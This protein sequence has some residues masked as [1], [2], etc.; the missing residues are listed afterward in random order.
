MNDLTQR[1]DRELREI[2]AAARP[3]Q[4][5]WDSITARLG[6]EAESEVVTPIALGRRRPTE[7]KRP[8]WFA[9]VAASIVV[10][11]GLVAMLAARARDND[12]GPAT[13]PDATSPS[14]LPFPELTTTFVSPRMGFSVDY[15]DRGEGTLTP[16]T[17]PWGQFVGDRSDD[18]FDLIETGFAAMFKGTSTEVPGH[19][20]SIDVRIDEWLSDNET[21]A[22]GRCG[23]PRDQQA[24]VTIDGRS[25][26]IAEC[27]NR[28]EATVVAG[29]RLYYFI[30]LHERT[31]ARR[32]FDAFAATIHLTPQTAV[33]VP[34]LTT[35]FVSPTNEFSFDYL[36][37]GDGT[38]T[39]ATRLWDPV[40]QPGDD[41]DQSGFDVVETGLGAYFKGASTAIPDGVSV[42]QWIDEHV[43]AG[44]CGIPRSKQ[45]DITIDGHVGR[46]ATCGGEV[47]RFEA[48]VVAD[49]RLFYFILLSVRTDAR[50]F[51]DT[52]ANTIRFTAA[53]AP[54]TST[55]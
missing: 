26:R 19:D 37:R 14:G 12:I 5:A 25:G 43:S 23:V 22:P 36:D 21:V 51:F 38:L 49:G 6:G 13:T 2:A 20:A 46:M 3:S 31:D 27:A 50:A 32:V 16:A 24:E 9:A 18:G 47:G 53:T 28:I 39:P 17:R 30:L 40:T 45:E 11:V 8:A 29:E 4:T 7:S 33:D 10:I 41:V 55:P 48:T 35:T 52:W 54:T 42:D 34:P 44:G 1:L 15:Q